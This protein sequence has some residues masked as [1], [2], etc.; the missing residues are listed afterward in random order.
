MPDIF[1]AD[2]SPLRDRRFGDDIEQPS[3]SNNTQQEQEV[4]EQTLSPKEDNLAKETHSITPI[5]P[6]RQIGS[7]QMHIF[8]SYCEK[9]DAVTFQTQEDGEEILLLIRKSF[10]TNIPW[11][12]FS[13]VFSLLPFLLFV[14]PV[15]STPLT[16]LPPAYEFVLLALYYLAIGAYMMVSFITWFFNTSLVTTERILDIDFQDL[17]YKNIAETKMDLI[18]D[19]S[20]TETGVLRTVFNFGDVLVQTAGTLE[21]FNLEAVPH[22]DRVVEIIESLIGKGGPFG[23]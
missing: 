22:P 14:I 5:R 23:V 19:V 11:I 1:D 4:V 8:S 2:K 18:Q 12:F 7:S 9:P 6:K 17:V 20:E 16:L 15:E 3:I 13:V 21:N 10:Y